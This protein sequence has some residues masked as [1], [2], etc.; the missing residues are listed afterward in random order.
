MRTLRLDNLVALVVRPI[1][2][3]DR[4]ALA[5][6]FAK[7]SSESRAK[8]F[9]GPKASLTSRDC[10]DVA[11][12]VADAWQR[13]GIGSALTAQ[14]IERAGANGFSRLTASTLGDNA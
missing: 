10:A 8:R 13:R 5:A 7:L 6:A 3:A 9:L 11:I 1:H 12:V 2:P 4:V 14:L